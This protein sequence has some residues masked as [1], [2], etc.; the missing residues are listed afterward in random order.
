MQIVDQIRELRVPDEI[1]LFRTATRCLAM[2]SRL[3]SWAQLSPRQDALLCDLARGEPPA[4]AG[5][6]PASRRERDRDLARL[7]LNYLV[8]MPGWEPPD[9]RRAQPRLNVVYYAITD[10]CNLR[11]PYCYDASERRLPGELAHEDSLRLMGQIAEAGAS[12]IVFTGGEPMM[13]RDLFDVV[14]R[15]REVG[16]RANIIT[17]GSYIR[18]IEIARTMAELFNRVTVSVDGGVKERHE[19][20]RGKGTFAKVVRALTLLNE[21]GVA[22]VINHVV[23]NE[24]VDY[25]DEIAGLGE[26]FRIKHVRVQWHS[27]LGRGQW[28]RL[29]WDWGDYL[30]SEEFMWTHPLADYLIDDPR[31]SVKP[32]AIKGNCGM[33]GNEIFVSSLGDVYPCKLVR[34]LGE[35]AG[36]VRKATVSEL[37]ATPVMTELRES[38]VF[39][40]SV[41]TDCERCYIKGACGGGCRAFHMAQSGDIRKNSRQLCRMLRHS[42]ISTIW[43]ALGADKSVID[44][45]GA[46][47]PILPADG[48]V[49]PVH[50]DWR[51][52]QPKTKAPELLDPVPA[53]RLLPIVG[54][55]A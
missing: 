41:H 4:L 7:V 47:V 5:D 21:A 55:S 1:V 8:Y 49:H 52:D 22:P 32:C 50:E 33:G 42:Q 40:G 23:S 37:F 6:D 3:A 16:L 9:V 2:N 10:G 20:T 39:G 53:R 35:L 27:N 28:D 30:K 24:N 17:N 54:V 51:A 11:C 13:R 26:R 29:G 14:R 12:T 46:F 25:L 18:N 44:D 36:N 31:E 48:S 45:P 43:R 19:P 34:G 15:A 38:T